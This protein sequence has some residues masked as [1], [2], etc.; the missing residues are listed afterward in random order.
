[1]SMPGNPSRLRPDDLAV[2]TVADRRAIDP[3]AEISGVQLTS[4]LPADSNGRRRART[5]S[6]AS[7]HWSDSSAAPASLSMSLSDQPYAT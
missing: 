5:R 3:L 2:L 6:N 4:S 7:I 1:M